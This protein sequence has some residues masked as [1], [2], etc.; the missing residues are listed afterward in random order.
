MKTVL[1]IIALGLFLNF[2]T[3]KTVNSD[4]IIA[5]GQMPN[6][7]K[8]KAGVLHLIYGNGDSIL[9]LYSVNG[10]K[11]FTKPS[12]VSQL[13][14]LAASHTRGPQIAITSNGLLVTACNSEGN[15][16]SFV[17]SGNGYW[18]LTGKVNDRDTVAKENLMALGADG[19]NA[20]AVWLDLR[21]GFNKIVGARSSD[22]GKSWSKNV[23]VYASPDKTV[24]ECC[25]PSVVMRG[26]NV[27]VMFRNW[28]NGN[29][30]LYLIASN[31]AGKNFSKAQKLGSGSWAL[32]GCPMD[33][34][35]LALNKNAQPV[36]VWNRKGTIYACEPGKE[37]VEIGK[38]RSCTLKTVNGKNVYAWLENGEVVVLK[39]GG[40][41]VVL[42]KGMQPV[43]EP[44]DN[45]HVL[46]LWENE[47]QIHSAIV[48]L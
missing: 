42:E 43:L 40:Q 25:R 33:G 11:S 26:A 10:G 35:G 44:I 7:I 29:R 31:D 1:L 8:D 28:L 2:D 27:Y 20:F 23:L 34:G 19:R 32:K 4:S 38:G 12:L 16:F 45:D 48:K 39:P 14:K 6:A 30:D 41:K 47:K 18:K 37:E 15:I 17:K 24:C 21:D 36:T 46:C 9:Y 5:N 22:G 13:P 3:N